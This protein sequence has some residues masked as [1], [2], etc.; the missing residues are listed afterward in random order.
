VKLISTAFVIKLNHK[1]CFAE[2]N[3]SHCFDPG[4]VESAVHS[5]FYPGSYP[6]IHGGV[7]T[8]AGA[9]AFY[10]TNA[11]AFL[12]GN[13]RTAVAASMVF[14]ELNGLEL[15]F[16]ENPDALADLIEGC[17]AGDLTRDYVKDWYEIHKASLS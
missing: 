11:H 10:L 1:I 16:P 2:G 7:A 9:L 13:K 3:S 14:M 12:D 5:A 6:F 4:K 15:V 8:I 17:A